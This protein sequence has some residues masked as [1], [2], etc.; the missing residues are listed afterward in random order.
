MAFDATLPLGS[1]GLNISDEDIR[2]N[3]AGIQAALN[4]E[5][6]FTAPNWYGYSREGNARTYYQDFSAGM[7]A[8]PGTHD[9]GRLAINSQ[10]DYIGQVKY[11]NGTAWT[12][13]LS[14]RKWKAVTSVALSGRP[15]TGAGVWT[16]YD[17][18]AGDPLN[19]SAK[20]DDSANGWAY[21][22]TIT[23]VYAP[24]TDVAPFAFR[25]QDTTNAATVGQ[26]LITTTKSG[27]ASPNVAVFRAYYEHGA[28][29]TVALQLQCESLNAVVTL[30]RGTWTSGTI[31][32]SIIIEEVP[33][34]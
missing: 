3:F 8:P 22:I 24:T 23:L 32:D 25:L 34:I 2:D 16:Q 12:P 29:E 6:D 13:L 19:I 9:G 15:G 14:T 31:S 10:A 30:A 11:H 20:L 28:Q 18:T 4:A 33:V 17:N 5:T 7:P 27:S 26:W 1:K 21:M